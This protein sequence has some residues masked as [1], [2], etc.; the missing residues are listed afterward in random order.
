MLV[1]QS[2]AASR[3]F[4]HRGGIDSF[5]PERRGDMAKLGL[6]DDRRVARE[7]YHRHCC[8]DFDLVSEGW[9]LRAFNYTPRDF[10]HGWL[11]LS[12]VCAEWMAK[13]V[14]GGQ[15]RNAGCTDAAMLALVFRF[16]ASLIQGVFAFVRAIRV[17]ETGR[18]RQ[19]RDAGGFG[20]AIFAVAVHG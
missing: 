8:R 13:A 18:S 5:A 10:L 17:A 14:G 3:I 16:L 15:S 7:L 19:G 12:L 1:A 9:S 20:S 2:A 4:Q 6:R 11:V